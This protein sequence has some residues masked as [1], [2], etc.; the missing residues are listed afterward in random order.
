MSTG[1]RKA[2][3]K[4]VF[5]SQHLLTFFPFR[6]KTFGNLQND[7]QTRVQDVYSAS[8]LQCV[9]TGNGCASALSA[10]PPSL[11]MINTVISFSF[12]H[13]Q[14]VSCSGLTEGINE[15]DSANN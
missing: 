2:A 3:V 10:L 5:S 12:A 6:T 7:S 15:V 4:R 9:H 13:M 11:I 8:L 1:T 14:G